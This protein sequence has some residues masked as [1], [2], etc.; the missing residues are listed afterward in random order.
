MEQA[1]FNI[2][3]PDFD[4]LDFSK[5]NLLLDFGASHLAITTML[6]SSNRFVGLEFFKLRS[7]PR[8]DEL[9]EMLLSHPFFRKHFNRVMISFNTKESVLLPDQLYKEN[10][11]ER[12]LSTIHGDLYTGLVLAEDTNV[13]NIKNIY[14]VPDFYRDEVTRMFPNGHYLHVY[15]VVL[16]ALEHRRKSF[17]SSF[18]YIIFYP[19][20][21]ILCL[22][23][24]HSLQLIQT[25]PYDIPEDVS[26]HILNIADQF[27]LSTDE[28]PIRISGL[29]D[30]ESVLYSELMKYFMNVDTDPRPGFF[31]YD[32]CF[33]E[34]PAHFFTPF[35]SLGLCV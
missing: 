20:Q 32:E 8:Q 13:G 27:D 3:Q 9:R 23:K 5:T 7:N 25:F 10:F 2:K 21:I 24:D 28:I 1:S 17:P 31:S 12:V 29:I 35:F 34:F 4:Q 33:D 19:N 26:Y 30:V 18:L 15:S 14:R 16:K 22:V 11:K 6:A